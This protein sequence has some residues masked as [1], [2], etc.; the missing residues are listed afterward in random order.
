MTRSTARTVRAA[1]AFA[2]RADRAARPRYAVT[3]A[4][5]AT[6]ALVACSAPGG[7]APT[8]PPA[9]SAS[10]AS[11]DGTAYRCTGSAAVT[12]AVHDSFA[13]PE[14]L[15]KEFTAATGCV[16]TVLKSGDAGQLTNKLVLTKSAPIADAVFGIDNAFAGRAVSQGVLAAYRPVL[17]A[18]AQAHALPGAG[19]GQLT[20]VDFG[21]VCVNV[22]SA[23]FAARGTTPP[24]TLDDLV[25]PDY[26]GLF[27]TPGAATSSPGFAFL[28]A[29]IGKYGETGWA[30]Y[31]RKLM[32][33]DT[34]ITAGWT[35]AYT[36]DFSAGEGKGTRPV[37]LSYA[38]SIPF[39]IPEGGTAPTTAALLDT[40][41]RQ[42]EYA[43]VLTGAKNPEGAKAFVA[44][45]LT[46]PVQAAI[47][48]S[49]Y[50]YPVAKDVALPPDWARWATVA[51]APYA[52]AAETIDAHRDA[53]LRQW[54]DLTSG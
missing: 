25:K 18:G 46:T 6:S 45:L 49:M 7:A 4:L 38:S 8:S 52:V 23:W 27:V 44:W 30:D 39:T 42:V 37:V 10:T 24:V 16:V 33:N 48:E 13:L 12:V 35:E 14:A 9:P 29:T 53:W 26:K 5:A 40:C 2:H 28:L 51:P 41:F 34:L 22:D 47:P 50:V 54:T 11:V 1:R 21:D 3:L 43:G 17:P 20:P 36:V 31:W 19:A 32:T 15:L